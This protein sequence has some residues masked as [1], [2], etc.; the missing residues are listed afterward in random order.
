M[1][2]RFNRVYYGWI[3]VAVLT[4]ASFTQVGEFNPVLAVFMKPFG[5]D[6]GWSRAEV[7]LATSLGSFGGGLIGPL[8]GWLI[9]RY[10]SR[11]ILVSCQVIYGT[12]L[13]SLTFLNGSLFH[14]LLAF[15]LGRM[16]VQG[17][18]ALATQV[19]ISNWFIRLRG[20]AMG[21]STL[22]TRIGQAIL[23]AAIA[24]ITQAVGWRYAWLFLGGI[25]WV[26]GIIP[27][28]IFIRRCPED[29][30]YLPDGGRLQE[31][32]PRQANP[33]SEEASA[34]VGGGRLS[35]APASA[36]EPNWTL[37]EAIKSKSLWLLTLASALSFFLGAGLHLHLYPYLTDAGLTVSEAVLS[38]SVYFA[39]AGVGAVV[40][41]VILD[42]F[43]L[44]F[45]MA[46]AFLISG[47]AIVILLLANSL[48]L[49]LVFGVL[50]GISFGGAHTITQVM[51]ATYYGRANVGTISGALL[52]IQLVTNAMG[53]FF[54]GWMYDTNGNYVAV[55]TIYVVLAFIAGVVALLAGAPQLRPT[56]KAPVTAR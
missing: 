21:I 13:L 16:V 26:L 4:A 34:R 56:T 6:F 3:M 20:Q 54:G 29:L 46:G 24:L 40:W 19:A 33:L 14:F 41:G 15:S 18:T 49:A 36:L 52:P 50:F 44:R 17:G 43:P 48:L 12:C 55:F 37:R 1:R 23:P 31:A 27:S 8:T 5:D 7:S 51:W 38:M 2:S 11:A 22:G 28:S 39:V 53:P 42:H 32:I 35:A 47:A 45:C 10:G 30:G 9:D 25:V